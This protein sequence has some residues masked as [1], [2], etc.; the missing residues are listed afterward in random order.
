MATPSPAESYFATGSALPDGDET[1]ADEEDD[2]DTDAP[3]ATDQ[4]PVEL[5]P[6]PEPEPVPYGPP[7][8]PYDA[9]LSDLRT[10]DR[11]I[12]KPK[13]YSPF[14]GGSSKREIDIASDPLPLEATLE[15]RLAVWRNAPGG[16]GEI[17]GE[18]ELGGFMQVSRPLL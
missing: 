13:D 6:E 11:T 15:E 3:A 1:T 2:D 4:T 12:P 7:D 17:P 10:V 9:S 18:V 16:R 14:Y 5:P 8:L